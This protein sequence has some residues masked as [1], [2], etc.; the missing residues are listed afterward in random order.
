MPE[1]TEQELNRFFAEVEYGV[2][3]V[4][5]VNNLLY[6][7]AEQNLDVGWVWPIDYVHDLNALMRVA[8]K[9]FVE[10]NWRAWRDNDGYAGFISQSILPRCHGYCRDSQPTMQLMIARALHAAIMAKRGR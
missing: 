3:T 6:S 9:E 10:Y 8:D 1:L 2:D 4:N 7:T 5:V